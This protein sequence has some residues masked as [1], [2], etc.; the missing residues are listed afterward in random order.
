MQ[1]GLNRSGADFEEFIEVGTGNAQVLEAF[2][3]R[4]RGVLRLRQHP[5]V[6]FELR[7][8][9]VQEQFGIGEILGIGHGDFI[10]V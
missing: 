2:Q 10:F 1:C 4:N 3:Q 5:E 6:E 8:F 7:Q 9:P